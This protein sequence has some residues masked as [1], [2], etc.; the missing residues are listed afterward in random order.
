MSPVKHGLVQITSLG[1]PS[2][3]SDESHIPGSPLRTAPSERAAST[4]C[5]C[6]APG[7]D[8]GYLVQ[9]QNVSSTSTE[10]FVVQCS[11]DLALHS[12]NSSICWSA[13]CII[14]IRA[15]L[16]TPP[17]TTHLA[18]AWSISIA[19]IPVIRPFM[20]FSNT[21]IPLRMSQTSINIRANGCG[22]LAVPPNVFSLV[23]AGRTRDTSYTRL[24]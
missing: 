15:D 8:S 12:M 23:P 20:S 17:A 9:A 10:I 24:K 4:R 18:I 1:S 7:S 6:R 2:F 19:S 3:D 21:K 16:R 14:A 5:A 22:P 11:P 13:Q